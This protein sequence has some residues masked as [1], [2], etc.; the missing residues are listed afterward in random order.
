MSYCF[1]SYGAI[2]SNKVSAANKMATSNKQL[3]FDSQTVKGEVHRPDYSVVTGDSPGE[4][5]GA[6]RMRDNFKD[7]ARSD[8]EEAKK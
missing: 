3:T 2:P 7:H 6:L 8:F 4:G 1:P 5:W